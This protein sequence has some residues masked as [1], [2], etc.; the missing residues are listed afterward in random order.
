VLEGLKKHPVNYGT[1]PNYPDYQKKGGSP[2]H[3]KST[4]PNR[5]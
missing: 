2:R 4:V 3:R 5:S 1:R